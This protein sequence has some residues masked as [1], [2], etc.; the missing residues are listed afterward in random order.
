MFK[1]HLIILQPRKDGFVSTE[2]FSER[3]LIDLLFRSMPQWCF[4]F[5]M[6]KEIIDCLRRTYLFCW[7]A[8]LPSRSKSCPMLSFNLEQTGTSI[9]IFAFLCVC[10]QTSHEEASSPQHGMFPW[11]RKALTIF[12]QKCHTMPHRAFLFSEMIA[13]G[14]HSTPSLSPPCLHIARQSRS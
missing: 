11:E 8:V 5:T 9:C 10:F 4:S 1:M 3:E 12:M 13:N 7:S 6:L 14:C 2:P